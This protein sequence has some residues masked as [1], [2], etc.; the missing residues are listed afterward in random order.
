VSHRSLG[1]GLAF[2][3]PISCGC[4]FSTVCLHSDILHDL[5]LAAE[6]SRA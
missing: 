6:Q 4:F 5:H 2:V 3:E 1:L